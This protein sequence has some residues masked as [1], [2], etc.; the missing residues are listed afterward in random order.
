MA[1]QA[2]ITYDAYID[3]RRG[4]ARDKAELKAKG[5]ELYKAVFQEMVS[6]VDVEGD[7]NVV[8]NPDDVARSTRQA[9]F[10]NWWTDMKTINYEIQKRLEPEIVE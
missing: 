8:A 1:S 4:T 10:K 2:L 6:L 7:K 5:E 3:S 9:V